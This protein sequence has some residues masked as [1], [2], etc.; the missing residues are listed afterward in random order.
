MVILPIISVLMFGWPFGFASTPYDPI[1]ARRYPRRA[2]W[3]SLAGPAANLLL[4][5]TAGLGLTLWHVPW[6]PGSAEIF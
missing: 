4:V 5:A 6:L 1:W 3:M 2:A